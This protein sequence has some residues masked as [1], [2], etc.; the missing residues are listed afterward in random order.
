MDIIIRETGAKATL[1][2]IDPKSGCNWIMDPR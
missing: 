1:G 2:I